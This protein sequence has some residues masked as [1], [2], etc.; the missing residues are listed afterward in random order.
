MHKRVLMCRHTTCDRQGAGDVLQV[1][2]NHA[3]S[4]VSIQ[5]VACLGQCGSG[6]MVLVL[7]EQVWYSHVSQ[8]DAL[9]I[10]EQHLRKGKVVAAKLYLQFHPQPRPLQLWLVIMLISIVS[11]GL[12]LALLASQSEYF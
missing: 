10:A 11:L 9:T 12:L 8:G 6:P 1:L 4:D 5:V 7:P 2:Q 3:P